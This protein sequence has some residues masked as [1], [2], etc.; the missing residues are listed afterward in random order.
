MEAR[1]SDDGG[2]ESVR[3]RVGRGPSPGAARIA[4]LALMALVVSGCPPT[5]PGPGGPEGAGIEIPVPSRT[6]LRDFVGDQRDRFLSALDELRDGKSQ[7][8]RRVLEDLSG[9]VRDSSVLGA[10][11]ALAD[12]VDGAVATPSTVLSNLARRATHSRF[13]QLGHATAAEI[14]ADYDGAYRAVE[15]VLAMPGEDV[16]GDGEELGA[17]A[18]S[19]RQRAADLHLAK[20]R[21]LAD[22]GDLAAALLEMEAG[23]EARPDDVDLLV[24]LGRLHLEA[25]NFAQ[26]EELLERARRERPDDVY[27][28]RAV[29]DAARAGGRFEKAR[30]IYERL[31]ERDP[32]DERA[33]SGLDEVME[34]MRRLSLPA[35]YR[36][37]PNAPY[38]TRAELAA[39]IVENLPG[40]R[41]L[42]PAVRGVVVTDVSGSWAKDYLLVAVGQGIVEVYEDHTVGTDERVTRA[43]LAA[44]LIR[45]LRRFESTPGSLAPDDVYPAGVIEDLPAGHGRFDAVVTAL[46][47]GLMALDDGRLFRPADGASG[48]EVVAAVNRLAALVATAETRGE[49]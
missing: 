29:A 17:R 20:G 8:A 22:G 30:D 2:P 7:R 40:L 11:L 12:L 15:L 34:V 35:R 45:A 36:E 10:A 14:G 31:L 16:G 42:P 28:D 9:D 18:R 3:V 49:P 32:G 27:L 33:R 5:G 41:R 24:A 6:D 48:R 13:V 1:P 44:A 37:L 19:L 4:A 38:V 26:S 39:L 21:S 23:L 43:D 47:Y 46:N 25:G